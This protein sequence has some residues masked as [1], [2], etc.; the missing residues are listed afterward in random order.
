MDVHLKNYLKTLLKQN[1]NFIKIINKRNELFL[2]RVYN[3]SIK[4]LSTYENE[5]H[6]NQFLKLIVNIKPIYF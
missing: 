2:D 6:S 1:Y 3:Y 5:N 4:V